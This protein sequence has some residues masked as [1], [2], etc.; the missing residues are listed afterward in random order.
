[1]MNTIVYLETEIAQI[2]ADFEE[3]GTELTEDEYAMEWIR[4]NGKTY[5]QMHDR[6]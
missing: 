1:M 4:Q 5:A 6:E 2:R 3:S